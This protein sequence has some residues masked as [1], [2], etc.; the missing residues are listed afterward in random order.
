MSLER[1]GFARVLT[2]VVVD[3][4]A[5]SA[6]DELPDVPPGTIVDVHA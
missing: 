2:R 1:V 5:V 4:V 6:P 3:P